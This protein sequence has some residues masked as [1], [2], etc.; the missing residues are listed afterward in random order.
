MEQDDSNQEIEEQPYGIFVPFEANCHCNAEWAKR[1]TAPPFH[2]FHECYVLPVPSAGYHPYSSSDHPARLQGG[3]LCMSPSSIVDY[4]QHPQEST[5]PI[6]FTAPYPSYLYQPMAVQ[7][8]AHATQASFY[9]YPPGT[10]PGPIVCNIPVC[11][12]DPLDEIL[13]LM[14]TPF[15]GQSHYGQMYGQAP[16]PTYAPV[17]ISPQSQPEVSSQGP[18]PRRQSQNRSHKLML[19]GTY[20]LPLTD[21]RPM[22]HEL[23]FQSE[24]QYRFRKSKQT[25]Y[26]M[27]V[28]NIDP[29]STLDELYRFFRQVDS[30]LLPP[31]ESAVVS[32]H[33]IHKSH[34]ALVNYKTET[35]LLKSIQRFHGMRLGNNPHAPRLAC[36]R[37]EHSLTVLLSDPHSTSE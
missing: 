32:I 21:T 7:L 27:W 34:C 15:W 37:K 36:R 9:I 6:L 8:A 23:S 33:V 2:G 28:G 31:S 1:S 4:Y 3:Q 12:V 10:V 17:N 29:K 18:G 13:Q 24:K 25:E 14:A 22:P 20:G 16:A 35:T 19:T 11:L 26:V 30:E 5:L